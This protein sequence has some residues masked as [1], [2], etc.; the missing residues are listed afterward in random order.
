MEPPRFRARGFPPWPWAQPRSRER[1]PSAHGGL[2]LLFLCGSNSPSEAAWTAPTLRCVL[3]GPAQ[4]HGRQGCSWPRSR[5]THGHL[6]LLGA[7]GSPELSGAW[8]SAGRVKAGPQGQP[9]TTTPHFHPQARA[10]RPHTALCCLGT[11]P[12]TGCSPQPQPCPASGL[13][14]RCPDVRTGAPRRPGP[15]LTQPR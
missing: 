9:G 13:L 8:G 6:P 5:G 11:L 4:Q 10:T 15:G 7:P 2:P 3:A 14:P 12:P 1:L